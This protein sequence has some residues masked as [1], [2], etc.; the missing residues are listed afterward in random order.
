M[1][2]WGRR[3]IGGLAQAGRRGSMP[4]LPVPGVATAAKCPANR[5]PTQSSTILFSARSD[6]CDSLQVTYCKFLVSCSGF[7]FS[8]RPRES[9]RWS[10]LEQLLDP[11]GPCSACGAL[12]EAN[13]RWARPSGKAGLDAPPSRPRGGYGSEMPGESAGDA[14][15]NNYVFC[16]VASM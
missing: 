3:T 10:F 11:G 1:E 15:F 13:H 14:I 4:C 8:S 16:S 12:G 2:R 6:L 7:A 9:A 5:L